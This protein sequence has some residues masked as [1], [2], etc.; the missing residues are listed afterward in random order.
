[1][2]ITRR[3]VVKAIVLLSTALTVAPF[4]TLYKYLSLP[5]P[6]IKLT[7]TKIANKKDVPLGE[8][9]RFNFP[10]KDR[11]AILIHLKPGEYKYGDYRQGSQVKAINADE[12]VAYDGICTHLGCPANW[13]SS[14]KDSP[15]PCHGAAYSPID[16]SVLRGPPPRPIPK[17]K[18]EIDS[19]G[20]IYAIGYESGL[21]LFGLENVKFENMK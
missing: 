7:R 15:C 13:N 14:E 5:V 2:S 21:P 16:G 3:G 19:G 20:D 12:F 8:G 4:G 1:M 6:I 9:I 17:V 10:T 11:P 18:I